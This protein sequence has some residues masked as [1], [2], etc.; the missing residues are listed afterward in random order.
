MEA[1]F[2]FR[3]TCV[4][5]ELFNRFIGLEDALDINDFNYYLEWMKEFDEK[6]NY[7]VIL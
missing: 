6:Y 3:K 4:K 5:L 2:F 1:S 7:I